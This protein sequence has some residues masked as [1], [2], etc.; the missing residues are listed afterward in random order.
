MISIIPTKQSR[1]K[2]DFFSLRDFPN[3]ITLRELGNLRER[4][5]QQLVSVWCQWVYGLCKKVDR[6]E[7]PLSWFYCITHVVYDFIIFYCIPTRD[8]LWFFGALSH[9][10]HREIIIFWLSEFLGFIFYQQNNLMIDHDPKIG[11]I[12]IISKIN[13]IWYQKT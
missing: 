10:I 12:N 2:V 7:T 9:I 1:N 4:H 13:I 5:V 8:R 11:L 3:T 6:K